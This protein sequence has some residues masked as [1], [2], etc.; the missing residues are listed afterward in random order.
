MNELTVFEQQEMALIQRLVEFKRHQNEIELQEKQLKAELKEAMEKY[1][2]KS[3]KNDSITITYVDESESVGLD[4]KAFEKAEPLCYKGL[5]E[6]Y[7]KVTKK[8]AYV[9]FLVK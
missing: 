9:R 8:T 4:L 5:L 2:I 1:G 6:D 7:P 3:F